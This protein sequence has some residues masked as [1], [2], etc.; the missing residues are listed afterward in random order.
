MNVLDALANFCHYPA[1][2]E[3]SITKLRETPGYDP[4]IQ[5]R[6]AQLHI[7]GVV[8]ARVKPC[9][10][11]D[12]NDIWVVSIEAEFVDRPYFVVEICRSV[13]SVTY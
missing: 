11:Q 7:Y 1:N 10:F 8:E 13:C 9:M 12:L 6:V 3:A 5:R 2:L 4:S